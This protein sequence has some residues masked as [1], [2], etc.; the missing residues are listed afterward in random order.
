MHGEHIC[1]LFSKAQGT[2][3]ILKSLQYVNLICMYR[4]IDNFIS[5]LQDHIPEINPNQ[6]FHINVGWFIQGY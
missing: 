6:T 4:V 3:F 1:V 5:Y 2:Y